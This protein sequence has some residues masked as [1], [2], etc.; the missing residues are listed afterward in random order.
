V[1][2]RAPAAWK[3]AGLDPIGLHEG[4]HT[5]AATMIAAGA[6]AT[7]IQ[8]CMGHASI[9]MTFDHYGHLM[10]GGQAEAAR[11]LDDYL[12]RLDGPHAPQRSSDRHL[13]Q[14]DESRLGA[15]I[16]TRDTLRR[17]LPKYVEVD[18]YRLPRRRGDRR[19]ARR[20]DEVMTFTAT[21]TV[22]RQNLTRVSSNV[23]FRTHS[24]NSSRKSLY[25]P[26]TCWFPVEPSE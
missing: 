7:V 20:P 2:R 23:V 19:P 6:N 21:V 18:V 1:R 13:R 24:W 12:A 26:V 14:A 15:P 16:I 22:P 9:T 17:G 8:S 3:A 10:P 4:R 25:F 11:L 5:F